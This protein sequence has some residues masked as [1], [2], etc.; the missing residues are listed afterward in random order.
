MTDKENGG[1][2]ITSTYIRT[3]NFVYN[4]YYIFGK[5]ENILPEFSFSF[6]VIRG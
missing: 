4:M 5:H 3:F 6:D 1:S 2:F